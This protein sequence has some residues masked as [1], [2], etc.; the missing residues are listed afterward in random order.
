M[1]VIVM[2]GEELLVAIVMGSDCTLI[3]PRAVS[4][5]QRHD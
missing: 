2:R 5:M 4:G 1:C 3:A